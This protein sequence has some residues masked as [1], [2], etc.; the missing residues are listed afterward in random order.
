[1]KDLPA[2]GLLAL[3]RDALPGLIAGKVISSLINR[4]LNAAGRANRGV[5]RL[6]VLGFSGKAVTFGS[7]VPAPW[8]ATYQFPNLVKNR[9]RCSVPASRLANTEIGCRP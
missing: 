5:D 3:L 1:M 2:D 6:P 4:G 8:K 7:N 9:G